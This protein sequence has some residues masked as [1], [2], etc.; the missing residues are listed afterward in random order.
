MARKGAL[1]PEQI[2]VIEQCMQMLKDWNSPLSIDEMWK[3]ESAKG[4]PRPYSFRATLAHNSVAIEGV[5]V[6][7]YF[8]K[9]KVHGERDK[10]SMT[11]CINDQRALSID[12]GPPASHT[13][14]I[15]V[16]LPHYMKTIGM[17]H[18]HR[19]VDG[20]DG[21]AEPLDEQTSQR[22]WVL[23]VSAGNILQAPPFFVPPD[24]LEFAI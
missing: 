23:F 3:T 9:S 17:P 14:V 2:S 24:Q 22:L 15:G 13:N 18:M 4:F 5:F 21:Y 11:L 8:K 16:G 10:V 12:D 19:L 6:D 7:C 1:T 20:R